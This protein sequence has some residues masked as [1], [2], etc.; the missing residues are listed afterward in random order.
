MVIEQMIDMNG[1]ASVFRESHNG[2]A[3]GDKWRW[4]TNK[5]DEERLA[6]FGQ[7]IDAL[8]SEITLQLG[9]TDAEHIRRVG[10]LSSR[11]EVIGRGLLHFSFEPLSFTLGTVALW[12]HKCL[13]LMEVGHMA[14]HGAYDDL[15][16]RNAISRPTSIGK[17]RSTK[18][19]GNI[20]ITLD[21]INTQT[22]REKILISIS[23][24]CG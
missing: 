23:E 21:I 3:V 24:R 5:Q 19:P 18:R 12:A 10:Q 8:R 9:D 14:L 11:L 2:S 6:A 7:A 20:T 4:P 15:E 22:S 1:T 16:R 13:E 17:L